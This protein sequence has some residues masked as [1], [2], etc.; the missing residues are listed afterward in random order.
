MHLLVVGQV[1]RFARPRLLQRGDVQ[2]QGSFRNSVRQG[3]F[4]TAARH[5]ERQCECRQ[6]DYNAMYNVRFHQFNPSL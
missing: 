4:L 1:S 5:Y 3:F 2:I 6:A